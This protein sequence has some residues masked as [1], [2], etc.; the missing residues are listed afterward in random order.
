MFHHTTY[1]C[2][3]FARDKIQLLQHAPYL[4]FLFDKLRNTMSVRVIENDHHF[5]SELSRAG[6]QTLIVVAFTATW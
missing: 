1:I 3:R 5:L 6:G 2:Y 4:Y